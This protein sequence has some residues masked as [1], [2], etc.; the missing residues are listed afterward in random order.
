MDGWVAD[1][2][3]FLRSAPLMLS[4]HWHIVRCEIPF[5]TSGVVQV[6]W[7]LFWQCA[8]PLASSLLLFI[9]NFFSISAFAP[10]E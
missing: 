1:I 3:I 7:D 2:H 10:Y 9:T 4:K 8:E 5:Y 6:G